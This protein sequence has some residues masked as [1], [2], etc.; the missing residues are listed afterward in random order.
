MPLRNERI[1]TTPVV[2]SHQPL[3]AFRMLAGLI[4]LMRSRL[5][6]GKSQS[7]CNVFWPQ[8][9]LLVYTHVII[10]IYIYIR[11]YYAC[12]YIYICIYIYM[13]CGSILYILKLSSYQQTLTCSSCRY[14]HGSWGRGHSILRTCCPAWWVASRLSDLSRPV[15]WRRCHM[16]FTTDW[17]CWENLNRKP[18]GFY[19]QI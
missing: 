17:F 19:H 8:L 11:V 18:M 9:C 13:I 3:L 1:I 14:I 10:Y 12:V 15:P 6:F 16:W 7:S 5:R 4:P 2:N